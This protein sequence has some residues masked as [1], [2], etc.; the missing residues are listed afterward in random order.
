MYKLSIARLITALCLFAVS[1]P[2]SIAA[3]ASEVTAP[4]FLAD[5]GNAN[6]VPIGP[7]T[8]KN[9]ETTR[10]YALPIGAF[11]LSEDETARFLS[12]SPPS[13]H[14]PA[15]EVKGKFEILTTN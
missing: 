6:P 4:F 5:F 10:G 13:P 8:L 14:G 1:L 7:C 3:N 12:C 15:I 2:L 9:H 11:T